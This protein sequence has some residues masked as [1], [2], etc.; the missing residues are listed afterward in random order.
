AIILDHSG[1]VFRHGFVEDP[2][3][4]N[5]RPERRAVSAKHEARNQFGSR[6]LECSQCDAIR[7][8]GEACFH[9][10]FLPT[11][12]PR[13]VPVIDGELGLVNASRRA[14]A[15]IYDPETRARWHGM[16]VAI[17]QERDYKPGWVAHKYKEK[18]GSFPP[19]GAH[20]APIT[21]SAE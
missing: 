5:L 10:G 3:E 12:P 16:F 4:W 14:S 17:A 20:P 2:V 19:W 6:L 18:F 11:R 1:A 7:V 15:N 8:A 21:P 9:C 13:Y